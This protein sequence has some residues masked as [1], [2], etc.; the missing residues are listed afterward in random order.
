MREQVKQK[1][2]EMIATLGK[3]EV[4]LDSKIKRNDLDMLEELLE[5]MQNSAI[6]IGRTIEEEEGY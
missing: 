1:M 2:R 6:T 4:I 3:G 5:D